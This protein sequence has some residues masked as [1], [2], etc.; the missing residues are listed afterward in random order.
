MPLLYKEEAYAIVGA[1]FDV[2]NELGN[3]FLEAVYQEALTLE[4][5]TRK[6]PFV[7]QPKLEIN[8]KGKRLVQYYEP[9]FVGLLKNHPRN[10]SSQ[11]PR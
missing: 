4:L 8:Y 5:Q 11:V 7:A 10:Q 3:G 9:D 2:Y 6:I 1:C